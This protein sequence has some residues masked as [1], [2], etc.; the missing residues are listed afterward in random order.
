MLYEPL[1][2]DEKTIPFVV[3]EDILAELIDPNPL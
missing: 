1:G 2:G 3:R